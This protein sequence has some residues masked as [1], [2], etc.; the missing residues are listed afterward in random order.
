MAPIMNSLPVTSESNLSPPAKKMC[1]QKNVATMKH[2]GWFAKQL[3]SSAEIKICVEEKV[4]EEQASNQHPDISGSKSSLGDKQELQQ[5]KKVVKPRPSFKSVLKDVS[6]QLQIKR[7]NNS[8]SAEIKI[9]VDENVV[10]EQASNQR[11]DISD[12]KSSLGEK[13]ELQQDEQVVKPIP[14]F[15]SVNVEDV[16]GSKSSPGDKQKL[17]QDEKVVKPIPSFKSVNVEDV[18]G[19]KASP[20]DKQ[21]LQQDEK[22]V[23]PIP[24]FKSVNVEDVSTQHRNRH[25]ENSSK[26]KRHTSAGTG[27]KPFVCNICG[28][29]FTQQPNL[30]QHQ[31]GHSARGFPC[32]IC[33]KVFRKTDDRLIHVLT[34]ECTRGY[35]HLKQID[36]TWHCLKCDTK[37]FVNR[38]R[39][40]RHARGHE[41]GKGMSCPVCSQDFKGDKAKDLFRHVKKQHREFIHDLLL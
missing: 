35:R 16:S 36:N 21:K 10:E 40:E 32:P 6:T 26:H 34:Q 33:D 39:A 22:F 13:Q 18:S 30:D 7:R 11:P 20:G 17:Q 5:D 14:P 15:K 2:Y 28:D 29:G 9:C 8:S 37:N 31:R 4:V 3:V 23:K 27:E 1:L 25:R 12:S 41:L 38:E 24:S 19:S